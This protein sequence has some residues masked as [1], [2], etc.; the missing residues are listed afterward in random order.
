MN[1]QYC[2]AHK[3]IP[4]KVVFGQLPHCDINLIDIYKS[5]EVLNNQAL[6]SEGSQ[7]ATISMIK[8]YDDLLSLYYSETGEGSKNT[9]SLGLTKIINSDDN[10][11]SR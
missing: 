9:Y 8:I 6:I 3:S 10:F 11:E 1:T 5:E 7:L 2:F 4:Y